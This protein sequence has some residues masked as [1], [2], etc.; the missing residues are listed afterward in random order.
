MLDRLLAARRDHA[1]G[2][3]QD[4]FDHEN[5]VG[6]TRLGDADH[7]KAMAVAMSDGPGD[8]KTMFVDRRRAEFRD[9]TGTI[10]DTITSDDQGNGVFRCDGGSVSVWVEV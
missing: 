1:Y 5:V 9:I 3:Q 8:S 7:T 6:W 2:P 10:P 4:Y